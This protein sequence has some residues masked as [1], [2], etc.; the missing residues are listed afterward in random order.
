MGGDYLP[1]RP[2]EDQLKTIVGAWFGDG[3]EIPVQSKTVV[4]L[5]DAG[6]EAGE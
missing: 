3:L 1:F 4:F 6:W 2:I 5:P